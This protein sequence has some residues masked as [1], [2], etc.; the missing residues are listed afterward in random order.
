MKFEKHLERRSKQHNRQLRVDKRNKKGA[1][2]D[3]F[4]ALSAITAGIACP[5]TAFWE[6]LEDPVETEKTSPWLY[7]RLS[8]ITRIEQK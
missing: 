2:L 3:V 6:L 5:F 8:E 7:S 1:V 4:G